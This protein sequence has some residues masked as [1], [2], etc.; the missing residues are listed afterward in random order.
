[1]RNILRET[2]QTGSLVGWGHLL[3]QLQVEEEIRHILE[4]RLVRVELTSLVDEESLPSIDMEL[5]LQVAEVEEPGEDDLRGGRRPETH[6]L[7]WLHQRREDTRTCSWRRIVVASG[8]SH[9]H[10]GSGPCDG[11]NGVL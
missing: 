8:G 7:P 2:G 4:G 6:F 1:M 11:D 10:R 3:G 5:V 9:I